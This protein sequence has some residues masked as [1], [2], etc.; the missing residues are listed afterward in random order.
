MGKFFAYWLFFNIEGSLPHLSL[1]PPPPLI[2]RNFPS[3]A[4]FNYSSSREN[5]KNHKDISSVFSFLRF[6]GLVNRN[7]KLVICAFIIFRFLPLSNINLM[8]K[9]SDSLNKNYLHPRFN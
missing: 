2:V 4:L 7:V 1:Q 9:R 8:F 5:K 6:E 3:S